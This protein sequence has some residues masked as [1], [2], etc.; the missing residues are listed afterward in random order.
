MLVEL[1]INPLGTGT[2][3]SHDLGEILKLIDDSGI[4]YRL[5]PLGTCIE[6]EWETM[7]V[8]CAANRVNEVMAIIKGCHE[9][10]RSM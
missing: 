6:G 10:A 4:P 3:L 2:H 9:K 8:I 1:S 5:T 7:R